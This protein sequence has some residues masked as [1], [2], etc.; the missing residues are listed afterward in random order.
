MSARMGSR[1]VSVSSVPV[2]LSVGLA[3]CHVLFRDPHSFLLNQ[4]PP[5]PYQG[6]SRGG[7]SYTSPHSLS[8]AVQQR[9]G[10]SCTLKRTFHKFQPTAVYTTAILGSIISEDVWTFSKCVSLF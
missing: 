3:R 8:S 9:G 7:F 1:V 5:L 10:E 2:V 4:S 6:V